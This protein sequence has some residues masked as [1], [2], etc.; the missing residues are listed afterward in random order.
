MAEQLQVNKGLFWTIITGLIAYS[1]GIGI[2]A[3]SLSTT[4]DTNSGTLDELKAKDLLH[5]ELG[6]QIE[7]QYMEEIK[8]V[9]KRL[10]AIEKGVAKIAGKLDVD[11]D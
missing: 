2:W 5:D 6:R 4:V 3:G 8:S 9:N 1:I 7:R 11:I 10:N